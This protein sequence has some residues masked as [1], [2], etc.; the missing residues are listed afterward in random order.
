MPA[1]CPE[2][3]NELDL[4]GGVNTAT[5]VS[6]DLGANSPFVGGA[7]LHTFDSVSPVHDDDFKGSLWHFR[8][9]EVRVC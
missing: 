7:D 9:N 2:A 5:E 6:L 1:Y 4:L 8:G 3:A